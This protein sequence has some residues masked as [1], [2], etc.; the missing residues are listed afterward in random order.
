MSANN[1]KDHLQPG[2]KLVEIRV[3]NTKEGPYPR[4]TVIRNG[5]PKTVELVENVPLDIKTMAA[6][7]AKHDLVPAGEG[8]G[9]KTATRTTVFFVQPGSKLAPT[10]RG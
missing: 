4:G 2:E 1:S 9:V 6:F 7:A 10:P 8:Q 3:D 5:S